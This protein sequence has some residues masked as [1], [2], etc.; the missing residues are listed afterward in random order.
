MARVAHAAGCTAEQLSTAFARYHDEVTT[1]ALTLRAA[2]ARIAE[3]LALDGSADM[4][5]DTHLRTY[6]GIADQHDPAMVAFIRDLKAHVQ[7]AC[8]TNTEPEIVPISRASGLLDYFQR[9]YVS[10]ELK[11]R[12]PDPRI[13]KTVVD[14]IG[15]KPHRAVFIDDRPE[16]VAGAR[17]A[18]LRGVLF[19]TLEQLRPQLASLCGCTL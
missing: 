4:L 15:C 18:G 8:L 12:K 11:L 19:T 16:N 7:V 17:H 3:D 5:L 6:R 10:V 1:G 14:D 9:A 2:Y 13:Y